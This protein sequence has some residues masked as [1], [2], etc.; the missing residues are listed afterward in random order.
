MLRNLKR[1]Q[2]E[3]FD[4]DKVKEYQ[5]VLQGVLGKQKNC[6]GIQDNGKFITDQNCVRYLL[7]LF[8]SFRRYLRNYIRLG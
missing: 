5:Q 4:T 8:L 6:A 7:S 1:L 2:A 3:F